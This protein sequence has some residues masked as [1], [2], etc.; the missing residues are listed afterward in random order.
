MRVEMERW[1][2]GQPGRTWR[3]EAWLTGMATALTGHWFL[4][5]G[6]EFRVEADWRKLSGNALYI[7]R[8]RQELRGAVRATWRDA[9]S[10][11]H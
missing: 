1:G 4:W 11:R 5:L 6:D 10:V 3:I 8:T 9:E 2:E 7:L